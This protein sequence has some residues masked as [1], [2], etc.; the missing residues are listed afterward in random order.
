MRSQWGNAM[1]TVSTSEENNSCSWLTMVYSLFYQVLSASD[2]FFSSA[3]LKTQLNCADIPVCFRARQVDSSRH[4]EWRH[5]NMHDCVMS[6]AG[7]PNTLQISKIVSFDLSSLFSLSVRYASSYTQTPEAMAQKAAG[8]LRES[9]HSGPQ[10]YK[11]T[12]AVVQD[13]TYCTTNHGTIEVKWTYRQIH[14]IEVCLCIL[15]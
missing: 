3:V 11:I 2:L 8:C 13:K 14:I 1:Y 9:Y 7:Y 6:I 5:Y 4:V 10:I 15:K 12:Q